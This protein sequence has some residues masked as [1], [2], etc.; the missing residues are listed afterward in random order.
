MRSLTWITQWNSL[1]RILLS[2]KI[3]VI[4]IK[5]PSTRWMLLLFIIL[6]VSFTIKINYVFYCLRWFILGWLLSLGLLWGISVSWGV[7]LKLLVIPHIQQILLDALQPSLKLW[8]ILIDYLFGKIVAL[9]LNF[10]LIGIY[11]LFV[12]TQYLLNYTLIKVRKD[13]L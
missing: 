12:N 11:F 8:L 4:I 13:S 7:I 10:I 1:A 6:L 3:R 5:K 9:L 2:F